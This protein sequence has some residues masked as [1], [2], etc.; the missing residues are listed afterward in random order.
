MRRRVFAG[1]PR[2]DIAEGK[3]LKAVYPRERRGGQV[4]V[5]HA[6]GN[7]NLKLGQPGALLVL[8]C[9]GR[10]ANLA[11]NDLEVLPCREESRVC[12]WAGRWC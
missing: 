1:I 3:C 11:R 2:W 7:L 10:D 8:R 6:L 12:L 4:R 9:I 5:R